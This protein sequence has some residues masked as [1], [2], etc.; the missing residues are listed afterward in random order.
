MAAVTAPD[1]SGHINL[2]LSAP[3]SKKM[4]TLVGIYMAVVA[5]LMV[6]TTNAT[7]LPAAAREIGGVDIYGLAQGISGILSVSI[8]PIYG[9]IGARNP[10][11][12][13][14]LCGGSPLVG[15]AVLFVRGLA[16]NMIVI[17]VANVFWGLV[18]AGVFVIGFAMIRDNMYEK[19][20][21]GVYLGL[22]GTMM[23][24]G[25]LVGP[26]VG[27]LVIDRIG[28]R[29]FCFILFAIL[30]LGGIL[31]LRGV[32]ATRE[33][34]AFLSVGSG[35]IDISGSVFMMLFLGC[36]IISLSMGDS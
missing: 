32:K 25:M 9:F 28:W 15:A 23:S 10:S 17:I 7:M 3:D 30:A 13:R 29:V 4:L 18:S 24:L 2:F 22:V 35:K 31:I 26:F 14:L 16:P 11:M 8:M 34:T 6:S 12:K 33:Q 27:G 20:R 19:D 1:A 21:A 36:F 5:N